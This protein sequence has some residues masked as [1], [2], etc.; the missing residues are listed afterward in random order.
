MASL[1]F[2]PLLIA[3]LLS[4][5]QQ[6]AVPI[7]AL[8]DIPPPA[9]VTAPLTPGS[10]CNAPAP[11][12]GLFESDHAFPG[13]VGPITNPILTK[14][15]RSLTEARVLFINNEID[16][17][18]PLGPGD[19]QVY[20]MELRLAL[21]DR[22]TIIADKDG[23]AEIHPAGAHT[24]DGWL[25]MAFG[26]KYTLVRDV[27]HQ[28]LLAAGFMFEPQM[29]EGRVFQNQGHG[30]YTA[31]LSG[32][33]EFK[34]KYHLI[35]N[36]GYQF[37][38]D[39]DQNSSFLYTSIHADRQV[40]GWLYPLV[41]FN[42]FHYVASGNRG[43]PA[44][45]GEGDGLLNLGTTSIQGHNIATGAAGVKAVLSK[46]METG[47]AWEVPVSFPHHDLINNRITMELILRY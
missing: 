38:T 16:P 20:A 5:A 21:T 37:P 34:E 44:A 33:Q 3:T 23:Y 8:P 6:P 9:V 41:E 12:R 7:A 35:G 29:G 45:V 4:A 27:E 39:P 26:L 17:G 24:Q 28:S 13:F 30:L 18:N 43:I 36:F 1:S 2:S 42:W 11:E 14:D 31:F 19:F 46:H 40:C 10:W 22:L 15:P 32:G 25:N 47:I